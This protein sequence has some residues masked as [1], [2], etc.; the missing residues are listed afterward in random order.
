MTPR[1]VPEQ[2]SVAPEG[3]H[4]PLL[5]AALGLSL[6]LASLWAAGAYRSAVAAET[7]P[8]PAGAAEGGGA[9]SRGTDGPATEDGV[10]EDEAAEDR[11][12]EGAEELPVL[13]P[14]EGRL[15][16]DGRES[17]HSEGSEVGPGW[18]YGLPRSPEAR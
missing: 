16:P 17:G 4:F 5:G 10:T 3:R 9:E 11:G 18:G 1:Q 2:T 14:A 6:V 8:Q 12:A 15:G 13:S 7:A